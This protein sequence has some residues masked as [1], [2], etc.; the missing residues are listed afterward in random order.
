MVEFRDTF[1]CYG[2]DIACRKH[3]IRKK[4]CKISEMTSSIIIERIDT[5]AKFTAQVF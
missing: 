1:V 4:R 2:G 5:A 3:M